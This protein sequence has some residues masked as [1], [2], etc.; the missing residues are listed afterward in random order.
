VTCHHLLGEDYEA[1][2]APG[3]KCSVCHDNH[4]KQCVALYDSN[5][6]VATAVLN[7]NWN[8]MHNLKVIVV[9]VTMT[10]R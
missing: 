4:H 2:T 6:E 3:V 5:E 1:E 7:C 9:N 10:C 8:S